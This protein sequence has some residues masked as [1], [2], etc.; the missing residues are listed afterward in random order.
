MDEDKQKNKK[1]QHKIFKLTILLIVV[2]FIYMIY[3]FIRVGI[4]K[5]K[6][7]DFNF[8]ENK[9]IYSHLLKNVFL[10]NNFFLYLFQKI[11]LFKLMK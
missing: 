9:E 2:V 6:N 11:R 4:H 5:S 1:F 10:I 3:S 8:E 7:K